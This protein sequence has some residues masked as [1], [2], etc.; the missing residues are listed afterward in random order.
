[1]FYHNPQEKAVHSEF[2]QYLLTCV[3]A[4]ISIHHDRATLEELQ[5]VWGG[6][7]S[8][9]CAAIRCQTALSSI[10][11]VPGVH[12]KWLCQ[13][14][15]D[16]QLNKLGSLVWQLTVNTTVRSQRAMCCWH[17]AQQDFK[18]RVTGRNEATIRT[19]RE[20]QSLPVHP[21]PH[22]PSTIGGLSSGERKG[23]TRDSMAS[24]MF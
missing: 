8:A 15:I 22:P 2:N 4:A 14:P 24:H 1:M 13:K 6:R 9:N 12:L 16:S 18:S 11:P 21:K 23:L 7:D 3:T 10:L 5:S 17:Q 19:Q 20:R